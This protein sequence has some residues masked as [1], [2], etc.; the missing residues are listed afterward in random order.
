MTI[1]L[2]CKGCK[3]VIDS[4]KK[5]SIWSSLT[6]SKCEE[7]FK[8]VDDSTPLYEGNKEGDEDEELDTVICPHCSEEIDKVIQ[9][10]LKINDSYCELASCPKCNKI[11]GFI[12]W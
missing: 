11:L 4:D 2:K 10:S 1:R 8:Q 6:C 5:P 9:K 7:K 3:R 12:E